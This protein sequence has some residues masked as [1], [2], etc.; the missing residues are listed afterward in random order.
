MTLNK[1][2]GSLASISLPVEWQQQNYFPRRPPGP[3]GVMMT[4][5]RA[6]MPGTPQAQNKA[7]LD[8]L[9]MLAREYASQN[10]SNVED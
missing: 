5:N 9:K 6:A 1:L 4:K 7:H 2:Y 3:K 10:I 8:F